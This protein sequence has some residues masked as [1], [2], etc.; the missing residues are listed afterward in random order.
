MILLEHFFEIAKDLG[1]V[2]VILAESYS[3]FTNYAGFIIVVTQPLNPFNQIG[4][5]VVYRY[6]M[7]P[8]NQFIMIPLRLCCFLL[9]Y[10]EAT[11]HHPSPSLP[12][13]SLS[14]QN[15]LVFVIILSFST[16]H[17]TSI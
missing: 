7:N 15:E 11:K 3:I 16:H 14:V 5:V 10:D 13:S 6:V 2:E 12:W 4:K 1:L 17:T 9:Q 8:R